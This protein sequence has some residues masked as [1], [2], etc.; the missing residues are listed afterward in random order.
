[1]PQF[2]N[3]LLSSLSPSDLAAFA[4]ELVPVVLTPRLVLQKQDE[5]RTMAY[6]P[7]TGLVAIKR[8]LSDGA[9]IGAAM[10]GREGMVGSPLGVLDVKSVNQAEVQMIGI[11]NRIATRRLAEL[12]TTRPGLHSCMARYLEWLIEEAR[13]MA[14]CNALHRIEPRLAKWLLL[15]VERTGSTSLHLTHEFIGDMLGVQRTSVTLS[16]GV[17]AESG[18]IET[19]RGR[20]LVVR[21]DGLAALSC[22]CYGEVAHQSVALRSGLRP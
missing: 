12:T 7:E 16:L 3:R 20:I 9:V 21:R 15:C 4:A 19:H 14:V 6:F 17:L 1:L 8:V 11:G 10:V 2:Q 22:P 18:L 13:L 5:E